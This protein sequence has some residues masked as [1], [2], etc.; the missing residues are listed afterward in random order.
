MEARK[1]ESGKKQISEHGKSF[2]LYPEA[3]EAA[4]RFESLGER[5]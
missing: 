2:E 1:K 3:L 4:A 5:R